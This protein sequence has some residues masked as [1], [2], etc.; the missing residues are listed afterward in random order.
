MDTLLKILLADEKK[1]I[2]L[3]LYYKELTKNKEN[4]TNTEKETRKHLF[5]DINAIKKAN[6]KIVN[7]FLKGEK[8]SAEEIQ[9]ITT[10]HAA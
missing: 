9:R 4:E 10:A 2:Q 1:I 6:T 3:A 7:H 5:A 8:L